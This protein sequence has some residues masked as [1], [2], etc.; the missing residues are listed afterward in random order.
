MNYL[1]TYQKRNGDIFLRSRT[2]PLN[3]KKGDETS[4]G[5]KVLNIH[6][7][8]E[9]NYYQQ[10]DYYRVLRKKKQKSNKLIKYL[11]VQL[12]KLDR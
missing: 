3:Y 10:L 11:I 9:G 7:Y 6:Y 8:H 5:W 2:T 12:N 4:M 1:I